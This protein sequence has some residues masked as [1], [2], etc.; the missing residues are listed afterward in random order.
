MS[1][2]YSPKNNI[3]DV[4]IDICGCPLQRKSRCLESGS[5]T[6]LDAS[7]LVQSQFSKKIDLSYLVH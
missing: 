7:A 5:V 2:V 6:K 1:C 4:H 3:I